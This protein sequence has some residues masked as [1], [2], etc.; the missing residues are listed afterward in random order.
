MAIEKDSVQQEII[1]K[2]HHGWNKADAASDRLSSYFRK[3]FELSI[4]NGLLLC[5][6]R[7]IIPQTLWSKVLA[8]LH[9][10]HA[11]IVRMKAVARS[12]V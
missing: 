6:R 3:R 9:K 12:Y 10:E 5:G 7:V 11:A 4:E 1:D 8:I 2:V